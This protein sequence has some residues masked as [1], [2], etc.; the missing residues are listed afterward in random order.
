MRG[1]AAAPPRAAT[2]VEAKEPDQMTM[3]EI[4]VPVVADQI[5]TIQKSETEMERLGV[6]CKC[7]RFLCVVFP[8]AKK[9]R[10]HSCH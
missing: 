1:E 2:E 9:K 6:A 4:F 8:E 3:L 10:L 5:A 7:S